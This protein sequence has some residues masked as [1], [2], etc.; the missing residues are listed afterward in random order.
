MRL[1]LEEEL[2]R[3]VLIGDGREV[4]DDDKIQEDKIRPIATD[5][6]LYVTTVTVNLDDA[7]SDYYELVE[8]VLRARRFYKGTGMPT[9]YTTEIHLTEMLLTKDAFDRRRFRTVDELA[10]ELRVSNIVAVEAMEGEDDL[11]A[12]IVNLQD[13]TI[14]ADRGGDINFFDDFDI[15]YNQYKYLYET[16]VSGALTKVK[17]AIV[18]RKAEAA[19]TLVAPNSPTFVAATGV[20]TIPSQTGVVY[21]NADTDATLSSGAQAALDPGQTLNVQAEPDTGYYFATTRERDWR[22]KRPAA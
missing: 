7:S 21:K 9:M 3:A 5:D 11:V 8:A 2:A 4:D 12:I 1:M 10:N 14:G 19:D 15:D 20:V 17:S 18:V 16:R 22:F 6:D 13:Y